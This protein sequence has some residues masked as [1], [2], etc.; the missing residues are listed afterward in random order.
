LKTEG[1]KKLI[2]D[3]PTRWNSIYDMLRRFALMEPVV[4]TTLMTKEVR[5]DLKDVYTLTEEDV[6]N[7]EKAIETPLKTI[8]TVLCDAS[9]PTSSL[10]LRLKNTILRLLPHTQMTVYLS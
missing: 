3:V 1:P 5:K 6:G 8:T 10:I 9:T 2:I 4:M 7:I